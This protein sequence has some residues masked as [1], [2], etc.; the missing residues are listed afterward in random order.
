MWRNRKKG[1]ER[2][3]AVHAPSY[4]DFIPRGVEQVEK[5]KEEKGKGAKKERDGD[6]DTRISDSA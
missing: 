6:R 4:P 5:E 3:A 2:D 1:R